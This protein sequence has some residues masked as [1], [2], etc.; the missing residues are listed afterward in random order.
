MIGV[1]SVDTAAVRLLREPA[2]ARSSQRQTVAW[3]SRAGGAV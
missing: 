1:S 3:R 2:I